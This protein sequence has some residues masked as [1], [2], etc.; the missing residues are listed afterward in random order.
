MSWRSNVL[1][2]DFQHVAQKHF[3][4]TAARNWSS[5]KLGLRPAISQFAQANYH[6]RVHAS[7][8]YVRPR[9]HHRMCICAGR[10]SPP[11]VHLAPVVI[12]A[13]AIYLRPSC[14][15][16]LHTAKLLSR[17]RL[18]ANQLFRRR[19][20]QLALPPRRTHIRYRRRAFRELCDEWNW[21][22]LDFAPFFPPSETLS[23]HFSPAT[24]PNCQFRAAEFQHSIAPNLCS[25]CEFLL[26]SAAASRLQGCK[27]PTCV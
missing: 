25:V 27:F 26:L 12:S 23:A 3:A 24:K 20:L 5:L 22:T 9:I 4:S 1:A 14:G 16:K 6:G 10:A 7:S 19:R 8:L 21:E 15:C 18:S 11:R 2:D 13:A 17:A